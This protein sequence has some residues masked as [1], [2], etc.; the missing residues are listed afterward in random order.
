MNKSWCVYSKKPFNGAAGGLAYLARYVKR[1]AIS[2]NRII[3]C[4]D[5]SVRFRWRDYANKN[6][7]KIM[8]LAPQEFIR[9]Y[10]S[11][12]LPNGFMRIRTFGFLANASKAK[13][14][15]LIK[16]SLDLPESSPLDEKIEE[17]AAEI[18]KRLTGID[19]DRCRVCKKG[20]LRNIEI[21]LSF[22][23]SQ[24]YTDTS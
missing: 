11:H 6:K 1:I 24:P 14:L 13:K 20:K 19:I 22:K 3:S 9:R 5:V 17:S 7:V 15:K 18:M 12:V 21:I 8:T 23:Q 10:L 2:N 4:D 16:S